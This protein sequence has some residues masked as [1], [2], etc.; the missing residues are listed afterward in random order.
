MSFKRAIA[1][2]I[3]AIMGLVIWFGNLDNG[4]IVSIGAITFI[5]GFLYAKYEYNH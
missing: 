5:F 1:G 2:G 3:V 4:T